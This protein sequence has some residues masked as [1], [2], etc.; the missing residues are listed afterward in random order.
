[1]DRGICVADNAMS[2]ISSM[3][4]YL[5]FSF[6]TCWSNTSSL[7]AI[8]DSPSGNVDK[9]WSS[10]K[11]VRG[12]KVKDRF[13]STS[14]QRNHQKYKTR[15]YLWDIKYHLATFF[16]YFKIISSSQNCWYDHLPKYFNI[17]LKLPNMTF[18]KS[19]KTSCNELLSTFSA[20][21]CH[22]VLYHK[23]PCFD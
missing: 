3:R 22:L 20:S 2:T 9:K 5:L 6:H 14:V 11:V 7:F 18:D 21:K 15:W 23:S 13:P 17:T 8:S 4:R 12:F 1:M 10:Y 16:I 19:K